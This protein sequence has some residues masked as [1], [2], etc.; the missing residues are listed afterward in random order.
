MEAGLASVC[1]SAVR[2]VAEVM[3]PPM[4]TTIFFMDDLHA[5]GP[6]SAL[7]DFPYL[8]S[9]LH[10]AVTRSP[11]TPGEL[12]VLDFGPRLAILLNGRAA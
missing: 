6:F 10:L 2:P 5:Y 12:P 1:G 3:T 8:L 9:Q 11:S 4:A 7:Y